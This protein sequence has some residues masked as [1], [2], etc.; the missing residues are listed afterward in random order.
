MLGRA[1]FTREEID[2]AKAAIAK[3]LAAYKALGKAMAAQPADKKVEAAVDRFEPLFFDNLLLALDRYFVHRVRGVAG[4]D[5]NP[6]NEV[7]MLCESLM[8]HDGILQKSTVLKLNPDESV[9]KVQFGEAIRLT[10]DQFKRL[11]SAFFAEL[12]A[13][14]AE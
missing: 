12:D 8:N 6:L 2:H 9:T 10:E 7:E 11:S 3:Q 14:F 5:G 13:K 4:K 1:T